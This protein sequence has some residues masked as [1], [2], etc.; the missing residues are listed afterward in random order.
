MHRP[1][2]GPFANSE[3]LS[4]QL[5]EA[6]PGGYGTPRCDA[7]SAAQLY[8][9]GASSKPVNCELTRVWQAGPKLAMQAGAEVVVEVNV[10]VVEVDDDDE[11][12]IVAIV[13]DVLVEFVHV[14]VD[15]VDE[16]F[17]VVVFYTVT[18]EVLGDT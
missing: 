14:S 1:N 5:S 8:A 15:I 13:V 12:G 4:R 17:E 11:E 18:D 9:S 6:G 2:E 16:S 7:I 3:I 10:L